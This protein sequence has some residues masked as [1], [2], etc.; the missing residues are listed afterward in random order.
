M[1]SQIPFAENFLKIKSLELVSRPL[2][3]FY[4]KIF[5]F[6][7]LHKLAK[8]MAK[9]AKSMLTSQVIQ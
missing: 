1:L 3:E 2:V 8:S 7:T 4:D 9:L 6:V 5:S